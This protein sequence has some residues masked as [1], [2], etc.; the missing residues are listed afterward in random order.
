MLLLDVAPN[1]AAQNCHEE[2]SLAVRLLTCSWNWPL[3]PLAPAAAERGSPQGGQGSPALCSRLAPGITQKSM[4]CCA[5]GWLHHR[6]R[7]WSALHIGRSRRNLQLPVVPAAGLHA[8]PKSQWMP[9][10]RRLGFRLV[11][12]VLQ[13][14]SACDAETA[15]RPIS[16][17]WAHTRQGFLKLQKAIRQFERYSFNK[18]GMIANTKTGWNHV[19]VLEKYT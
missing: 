3:A 18:Q 8:A 12:L 15:D 17:T 2:S 6:S 19:E 11:V 16:L 10:M 13:T 4:S 14:L 1:A 5:P 7:I 9:M